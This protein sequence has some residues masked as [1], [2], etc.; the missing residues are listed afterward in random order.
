MVCWSSFFHMPLVSLYLATKIFPLQKTA[1]PKIY[2]L[3]I[4]L[5]LCM[6]RDDNLKLNM[7]VLSSINRFL[8]VSKSFS[9]PANKFALN[10]MRKLVTMLSPLSCCT[11][12]ALFCLHASSFC[13]FCIKDVSFSEDNKS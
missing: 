5:Y 8:K 9:L 12:S 10:I 1:N 4:G 11:F 2:V 13:V 7:L 3:E 6:D